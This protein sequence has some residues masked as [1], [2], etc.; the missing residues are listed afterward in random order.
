MRHALLALYQAADHAVAGF[1]D[2]TGL[3]CPD[4]CGACCANSTPM[5][6]SLEAAAIADELVRRGRAEAV[7][8][9]ARVAGDRRC[10]LYDGDDRHG[11]CT[12][13]ALRPVMCRLYG[14]AAVQRDGQPDLSVCRVHAMAIPEA[15]GAAVALVDGGGA[16]PEFADWAAQSVAL[17]PAAAGTAPAPA[18]RMND[19]LIEVLEGAR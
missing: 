15:V 13:Y 16:V 17:A 6:S 5:V 12:V 14:F 11:R 4:G 10:A 7:L 1:A 18:R 19:A 2:A 3:R 9:E 8:A